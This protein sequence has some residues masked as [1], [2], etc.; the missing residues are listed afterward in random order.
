[1]EGVLSVGAVAAAGIASEGVLPHMVVRPIVATYAARVT[2]ASAAEKANNPTSPRLVIDTPAA[3]RIAP[4]RC[5]RSSLASCTWRASLTV[6]GSTK[7]K[8]IAIVA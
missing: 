7:V 8:V 4:G 6:R 2:Q 3:V 5:A 1:M